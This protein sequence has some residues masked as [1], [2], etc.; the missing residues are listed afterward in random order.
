MSL[1]YKLMMQA[2]KC[3]TLMM[4]DRYVDLCGGLCLIDMLI[5]VGDDVQ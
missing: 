1:L 3:S 2:K 4:F 5:Y